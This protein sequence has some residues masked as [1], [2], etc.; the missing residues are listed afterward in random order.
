MSDRAKP[1]AFYARDRAWHPPALAPAYRT[2]V[3]RSP[4]L[5]P[6]SLDNTV[7]EMSGPVFGDGLPGPLD[8]DLTLNFAGPMESAIGPRIVV[9]GRVMDQDGRGV[10]G[11]LVEV[12]QAN[13]GGRYRHRRDFY[14][15]PLDPNFGGCGRT[16]TERDGSY[17]F[18]SILPGPYP[19]PNGPNDWRPSHIHF[20]IF[21]TG[22]AQRLITQMY[23]E[24]DPLIARCPIVNTIPSQEAIERLVAP[25]D[26]ENT[27]PMDALAYRFD[28]VLRGRR[29][30]VFENRRDG[31]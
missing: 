15:A 30:T 5:A 14:L 29:Q 1:G 10:P 6:V 18:R 8:D 2:T 22:F 27:I 7:T 25:L 23:F 31:L 26:M 20:S 28:I 17:R 19:W 21:G 3:L 9:F 11:A 24:G 13:A 16:V 12:W 4:R